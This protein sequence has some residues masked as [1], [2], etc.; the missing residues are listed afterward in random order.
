MTI[1]NNKLILWSKTQN[2]KQKM[3]M[4][5]SRV[6]ASTNTAYFGEDGKLKLFNKKHD[7]RTKKVFF[8]IKLNVSL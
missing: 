6:N 1:L 8:S 5:Q 7:T 3:G 2:W 4:H